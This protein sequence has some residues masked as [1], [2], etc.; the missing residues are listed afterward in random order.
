MFILNQYWSLRT[1]GFASVDTAW[2]S[3]SD[4]ILETKW[5]FSDACPSNGDASG[6]ECSL[7]MNAVVLHGSIE[8]AVQHQDDGELVW[9]G[10]SSPLKGL[11]SVAYLVTWAHGHEGSQVAGWLAGEGGFALR[12]RMRHPAS[13][14][15]FDVR[16]RAR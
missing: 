1:D 8:V 15:G 6:Q 9:S 13:V 3:H 4:I 12:F 2:T 11:D 7:Y 10:W 16:P 14:Y 5:L